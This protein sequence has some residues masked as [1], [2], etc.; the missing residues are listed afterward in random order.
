MLEIF[1][2][3]FV[4]LLVI[5]DPL[6]SAAVFHSLTRRDDNPMRRKLAIQAAVIAALLLVV[7]A[8]GGLA[9]LGVL[10]ISLDAFRI[11]GG[12]LLFVTAFRMIMGGHD[13]DQLESETAVYRDRSNIAVFPMAI[14]LLAGPGCMT[15]VILSMSDA[16]NLAQK[17][18]VLVAIFC[19]QALSLAAMLTIG[20]ITELTGRM[21]SDIISRVVGV[22]LAALSVQFIIDGALAIFPD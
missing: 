22:L 15:A 7:F 12:L 20:R 5:A 10:G 13:E 9:L 21:G 19:V 2:V 18:M 8:L 11:A 6:G 16:T 14:P 3:S 4:S 1:L 17:S